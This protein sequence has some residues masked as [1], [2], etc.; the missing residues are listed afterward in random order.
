MTT[1]EHPM[2][3]FDPLESDAPEDALAT[4]ARLRAQCPVAHTDAYGGF[5]AL[6]RYADV[7]A[8]AGDSRTWLSSVRAVVPSDPRGLRRPPLNFDAPA[9]TPYRKALDRTLQRARI[10]ALEPRLHAHAARELAPMLARGS[11]DVAQ[12][13]GARFPAWVTTEWLN[14]PADVAPQLADTATSWVRAWRRMD[15]PVVNEMSERMYGLAR[16]LVRARRESPLP[17]EEDPA[18]SLL[19]ERLDGQPLAE[20]HLVGALRQSLVVGMVAPPIILGSICVHLSRDQALQAQLRAHPEL[21]PDA[22]EEF[23]RLYTPYRG[24]ARTAAHEVELHGRRI[25]PAEPVTLVYA[26]A[27][28]DADVFPDP[29]TFVLGRPNIAGHLAFGKGR[30]R[31]AGMPL[32]RLGL[33]VALETLLTCTGRFE[34]DGPLEGARMPEIGYVSVPLRVEPATAEVAS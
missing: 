2:P 16:D 6:T 10:A 7:A 11:G 27:N 8:A 1:E 3:D 28:R 17:V 18:S 9:H 25:R 20:E 19:S 29:D 4:Y 22:V 24:F 34:L 32:A 13:F 23:L 31:C 15:G 33:R 14:L 12:E 5:W 21:L 30:H 26:S